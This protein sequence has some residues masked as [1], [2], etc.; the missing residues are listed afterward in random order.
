MGASMC[1]G[2][3]VEESPFSS[4]PP[5]WDAWSIEGGVYDEAT[6]VD[7]WKEDV[8]IEVVRSPGS[9]LNVP[10]PRLQRIEA[11]R[12]ATPSGTVRTPL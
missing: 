10:R 1:M 12:G 7:V 8:R 6:R 2:A 9:D 5:A 3:R 4:V 11:T